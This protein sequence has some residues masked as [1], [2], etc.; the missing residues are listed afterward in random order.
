MTRAVDE[1]RF[2]RFYASH[3][4]SLLAYAARRVTQPEDAA[5]VVA[6]AF[7]VAWH[8]IRDLPPEDEGKLWMYGVARKILA[9]H[10]R[11]G[12]RRELLGQRL[13]D[14]FGKP[15]T[16]DPSSAVVDR[17]AAQAAL[18]LLSDLDREVLTLAIW[19]ELEPR[20][21][22]EVLGVSAQTVRTRLSRARGRL[23]NLIGDDLMGN[24]LGPAG[25]V[26][27]VRPI[28]TPEEGK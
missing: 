21:I 18:A 2:R 9:N 22:A 1:D 23:R 27:S 26:P 19:E 24:D 17:L 11:G 13:R 10:R 14:Q 20:E 16:V 6:D 15:V 25:H 4:D 28:L 5:D 3:F 8:R 12:R 7:L